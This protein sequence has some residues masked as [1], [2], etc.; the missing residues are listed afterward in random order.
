M[1]FPKLLALEHRPYRR[2]ER[3]G[4][5]SH[6]F[7]ALIE[8]PVSG[9]AGHAHVIG[10]ICFLVLDLP[11]AGVDQDD[12]QGFQR[13]MDFSEGGFYVV[14]AD[15]GA[16]GEMTKVQAYAVSEAILEGDSL[17]TRRIIAQMP[18]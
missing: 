14:H 1:S 15:T 3:H 13:V 11:R 7:D 16:F 12:I 4:I 9:F 5:D 2:I 10:K 17:R 6:H 8:H 18:Q